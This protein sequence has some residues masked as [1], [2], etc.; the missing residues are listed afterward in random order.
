MDYMTLSRG[1]LQMR[2]KMAGNCFGNFVES[3]GILAASGGTRDSSAKQVTTKY[4][5]SSLRSE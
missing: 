4:G 1:S 3:E 5:D 2:S